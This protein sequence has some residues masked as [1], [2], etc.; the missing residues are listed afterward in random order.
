M[1]ISEILLQSKIKK[2]NWGLTHPNLS[3]EEVERHM[4]V[5]RVN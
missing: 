2:Y 3:L 1:E 5:Y 4:Y